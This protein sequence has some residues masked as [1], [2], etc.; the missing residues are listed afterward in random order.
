MDA[1]TLIYNLISPLAD[2]Y[3]G[4][5][6]TDQHDLAGNEV[7]KVYPYAEINFPS[8]SPNN[9]CSDKNQ[10]TIDVWSNKDT[11]IR[12]I[13]ILCDKIHA[14]INR[15]QYNDQDMNCSIN[16]DTPYRLKIEDP[17]LY[18]QRRQLRYIATIYYKK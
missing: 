13:E 7:P 11:D 8:I 16:R 4:H 18:I 6:P 12:D 17:S 3:V 10:L 14:V 2:A 1:Y 5:Y 9:I 15:T